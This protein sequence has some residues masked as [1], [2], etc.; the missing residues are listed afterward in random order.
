MLCLCYD[1][2]LFIFY[3]CVQII[4]HSMVSRRC[5]NWPH[6]QLSDTSESFEH[7]NQYIFTRFWMNLNPDFYSVD[8]FSSLSENSYIESLI[9]LL[10]LV[11]KVKLKIISLSLSLSL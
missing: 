1:Y 4:H 7:L 11:I 5:M 8:G 9:V 3:R 10:M 6:T 2:E